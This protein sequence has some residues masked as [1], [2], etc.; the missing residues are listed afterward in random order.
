MNF[1]TSSAS[2]LRLK[3]L[4]TGHQLTGTPVQDPH[5]VSKTVIGYIIE[6][7]SNRWKC[8]VAVDML[9][10]AVDRKAFPY[11][12]YVILNLSSPTWVK[13]ESRLGI[14]FPT[15]DE[16]ASY[17]QLGAV[18]RRHRFPATHFSARWDHADHTSKPQEFVALA[19][20]TRCQYSPN[21]LLWQGEITLH[22]AFPA[23]FF[24]ATLDKDIFKQIR[25]Q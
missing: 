11:E 9:Y 12:K 24:E 23:G 3:V 17:T 25:P 15:V 18:Y 2:A 1:E 4:G 8:D 6:Q 7:V 21:Q 19:E 13:M 14:R 20:Y 5:S 22:L 16:E 10:N